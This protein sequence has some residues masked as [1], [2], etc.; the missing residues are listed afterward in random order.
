MKRIL[1]ACENK[2]IRTTLG[3]SLPKTIDV[4]YAGGVQNAVAIA[5]KEHPGLV[6][7]DLAM[8]LENVPRE[9]ITEHLKT[10]RTGCNEAEVVVM[11]DKAAIRN[12]V[13]VVKAGA[14]DY[15]TYPIDPAEVQLV[16]A[17]L[18]DSRL[19]SSELNHL[20][21]QFWREEVRDVVQTRHASMQQVYDK[22]Q[23]V[24]RT[25]STVLLTGETGTGKTLLARLIH[26]HSNRKD[27]SFISVHCGAIP[28]TLIE[29][30]LFGHEKGAFTGADHKKLGKFEIATKGTIFLDEVGTLTNSAQIKLLQVLQD[31]TFSRVGGIDT[32]TTDVRVIAATNDDLNAACAAGRFRKDL[33]YRLNV[34]PIDIPSLSQ[35]PNDIP[36][37]IESF[38]RR[39][40]NDMR[41][42]IHSVDPY[43]TAALKGYSWPG[44]IRELE[45]LVERAYI[46]EQSQMLTATSFPAELFDGEIGPESASSAGQASLSSARIQAVDDFERQYLKDLLIANKGRINRSAEVAGISARQLHK[47][48]Q[49]HNLRKEAFFSDT[50]PPK[51]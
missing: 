7:I 9:N 13:Q 45:N 51:H 46:L 40:N 14:A 1:I 37:L 5:Q 43:V 30:E 28:D 18:K 4:S 15:L 38:L 44:N 11:T 2:E 19:V 34:F 32:L 12:A 20:R 10:F 41:K 27:Q 17:D 33:Y 21:D 3:Q 35:H 31:G 6:L 39:L 25:K 47:L 36:A 22:I 29:S 23:L 16:V 42:N 49:K 26:S 24:A 8:L 50:Q 48:M